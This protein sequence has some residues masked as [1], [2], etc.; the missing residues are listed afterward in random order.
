MILQTEHIILRPFLESDVDAL[1]VFCSDFENIEHMDWGP[2]TLEQTKLFISE[3]TATEEC[4][5]RKEFSFAVTLRSS[6]QVIGS[7]SI[8]IRNAAHRHGG[9]GYVLNKRFWRNGYGTELSKAL[10]K[11]GF[12]TLRCHRIS[13]TC[14]PSNIGSKLLLEKVGF[15]LE[16]HL[17][18]ELYVRDSWRDSLLF[19]ILEFDYVGAR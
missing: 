8:W 6:G 7:C 2:N 16:G 3:V 15:K 1:H 19:S 11:F 14:S 12:E 5:N 10:I 18:D 4:E 17:R 13:A 9:M